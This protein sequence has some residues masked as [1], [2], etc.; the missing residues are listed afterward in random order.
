MLCLGT[1]KPHNT[2]YGVNDLKFNA[3]MLKICVRVFLVLCVFPLESTT[4][5]PGVGLSNAK[6]DLWQSQ[7]S[8]HLY[9]ELWKIAALR[10]PVCRALEIAVRSTPVRRALEIVVLCTLYL[11][12]WK[13]Q[14]FA[15]LYVELWKSQLSAPLYLRLWKS[16]FFAPWP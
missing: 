6:E 14:H 15:P 1:S 3:G 4:Q 10:T 11:G 13:S 16:L 9:Q 2:Q 7:Y 5:K 12:F 8:T